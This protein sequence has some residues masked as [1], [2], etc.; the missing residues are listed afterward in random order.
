MTDRTVLSPVEQC[1]RVL[2]ADG[3]AEVL[4]SAQLAAGGDLATV[5]PDVLLDVAKG[6]LVPYGAMTEVDRQQVAGELWVAI[7][8]GNVPPEREVPT[9]WII[10]ALAR[11]QVADQLRRALPPWALA[12]VD[13]QGAAAANQ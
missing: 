10:E 11:P 4:L 8:N 2:E 9:L 1:L 7:E 3:G 5:E 6:A 12:A 13:Q